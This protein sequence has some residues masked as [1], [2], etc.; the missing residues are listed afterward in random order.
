MKS[1]TFCSHS[2]HIKWMMAIAFIIMMI[3]MFSGRFSNLSWY[4]LPIFILCPLV[5]IGM[6]I[7]MFKTDRQEQTLEDEV[8]KPTELTNAGVDFKNKGED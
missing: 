8:S 1:K 3:L 6:M 5:M 7:M 4:L 2:G